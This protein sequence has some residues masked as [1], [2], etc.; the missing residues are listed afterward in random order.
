MTDTP[1]LKHDETEEAPTKTVVPVKALADLGQRTV[2]LIIETENE[3]L[4]FTGRTLT[5]KRYN[6]IGRMVPEPVPPINGVDNNKR[7][8]FNNLDPGFKAEEA[9]AGNRRGLL[10]LA[11]FLQLDWGSATTLDEK[12]DLLDS[13]LEFNVVRELQTAMGMT[14]MEGKGRVAARAEMF[15][16]NGTP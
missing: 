4:E 12:A 15:Q 10:R 8:V 11:E 16:R 2:T 14:L 5:N 7:P 1:E 6:D 3:V 9:R 13:T